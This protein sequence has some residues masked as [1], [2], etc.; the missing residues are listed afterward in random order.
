MGVEDFGSVFAEPVDA[1]AKIHG[2]ADDHRADAKLTD[3][4]AAIPA[5]G[6]RGYHDFVAITSLSPCFAKSIRLTMRGRIA[7]L[8][9]AVVCTDAF[10]KARRRW[11]FLLP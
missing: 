2:F 5:G 1:A 10:R 8:H 4:A 7:F 11:E 6:K 3:Q 9:S